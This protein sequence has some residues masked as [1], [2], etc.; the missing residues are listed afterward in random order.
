MY[1][2]NNPKLNIMRN[3]LLHLLFFASAVVNAQDSTNV[4]YVGSECKYQSILRAMKETESS[5]KI[6][7]KRGVYNIADEYIDYY[8]SDYWKNYKGYNGVEDEYSRGLWMGRNR[9]IEGEEGVVLFWEN[10]CIENKNIQSYFSIIATSAYNN[11]IKNVTLLSNGYLRYLVHDDFTG[12]LNPRPK[13]NMI[14]CNVNFEGLTSMKPYHQLIGGGFGYFNTYIL[15][16]CTF[17]NYCK[18]PNTTDASWHNHNGSQRDT[19]C[20]VYMERCSG[21]N[22]ILFFSQGK[23]ELISECYMLDCNFSRTEVVSDG[24]ANIEIVD[25]PYDFFKQNSTN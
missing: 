25:S 16:N 11:L 17:H 5:T 21:D 8:G 22:Q 18:E 7:I 4:V 15:E 20:Y 10:P 2:C 12:Y 13:G 1:F 14:Y 19:K 24:K 23:S 3:L 6:M 9:E